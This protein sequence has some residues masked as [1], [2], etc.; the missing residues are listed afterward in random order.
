MGDILH[1]KLRSDLAGS[2][3]RAERAKFWQDFRR[4][5][6]LSITTIG[7]IASIFFAIDLASRGDW[8]PV[9][10]LSVGLLYALVQ[11]W[12]DAWARRSTARRKVLADRASRVG[13]VRRRRESAESFK[14]RI[15]LQEQMA[16]R[17]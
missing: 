13:L 16:D 17:P 7:L 15:V 8:R 3:R 12:V 5:F 2:V 6:S 10:A 1:D 9:K 4:S 11:G 14:R